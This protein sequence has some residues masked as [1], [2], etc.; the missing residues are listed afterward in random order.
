MIFYRLNRSSAI[1]GVFESF[2]SS[3]AFSKKL[4][5]VGVDGGVAVTSFILSSVSLCGLKSLTEKS[6]WVW[7]FL[8]CII[9]SAIKIQKSASK[10]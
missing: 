2:S 7:S 1:W 8:F 5:L 3:M 10:I 9:V 4:S 6:E